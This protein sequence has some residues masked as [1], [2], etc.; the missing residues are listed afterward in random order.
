MGSDQDILLRQAFRLHGWQWWN[1]AS[2]H[3]CGRKWPTVD[4][5]RIK[6]YATIRQAA[7]GLTI[8]AAY[9]G[10]SALLPTLTAESNPDSPAEAC[11]DAQPVV[12]SATRTCVSSWAADWLIST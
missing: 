9:A 5:H 7:N 4:E 3:P 11:V 12:R 6:G 10:P 1:T 8:G 2:R